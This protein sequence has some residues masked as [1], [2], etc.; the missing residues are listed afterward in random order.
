MS[1]VLAA[2]D[3]GSYLLCYGKAARPSCCQHQTDACCLG[4]SRLAGKARHL[5]PEAGFMQIM[6]SDVRMKRLPSLTLLA[7]ENWS[8][9]YI[10]GL[11]LVG[12]VYEA[13]R[14]IITS[15]SS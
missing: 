5:F 13:S 8:E 14:S 7:L 2:N 15:T 9:C 4:S 6:S 12:L 11:G 10:Q 1:V 3:A